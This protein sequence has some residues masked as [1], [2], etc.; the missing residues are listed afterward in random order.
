MLSESDKVRMSQD[1]ATTLL[2]VFIPALLTYYLLRE[3]YMSET[4]RNQ[5]WW[6]IFG[7]L[8]FVV[9]SCI[10][11]LFSWIYLAFG[12][13]YWWVPGLSGSASVLALAASG[14]ILATYL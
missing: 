9:L 11:L 10:S 5:Y 2:S 3:E 1:L 12:R 7:C 13:G 4:V 14:L 6:P 8:T